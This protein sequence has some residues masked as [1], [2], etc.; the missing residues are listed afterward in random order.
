MV[1]SKS[2]GGY[3]VQTLCSLPCSTLQIKVT[4]SLFSSQINSSDVRHLDCSFII[5][6][7]LSAAVA[8]PEISVTMIIILTSKH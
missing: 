8:R 3:R 7:L 4:S 6:I 1:C 2:T 5:K